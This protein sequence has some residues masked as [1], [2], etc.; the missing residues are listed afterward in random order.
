M[1][2]APCLIVVVPS[3]A[4]SFFAVIYY[5]SKL[6]NSEKEGN[7]FLTKKYFPINIFLPILQRKYKAEDQR[8]VRKANEALLI[9]WLTVILTAILMTLDKN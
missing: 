4:I 1:N 5:R 9:Y 6:D 3:G 8:T 2:T 7:T